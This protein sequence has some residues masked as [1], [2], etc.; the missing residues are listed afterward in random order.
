M[1]LSL[2]KRDELKG[3][4]V[5]GGVLDRI[6]RGREQRND[7]APMRRLCQKFEKGDTYWF[8]NSQGFLDFQS[9]V[10]N[11]RDKRGKPGHRIRNKYNFIQP[12]VQG[13][14]SQVT[15]KTPGFRVMPT[16]T[17]PDDVHAAELASQIA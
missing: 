10:T 14:V 13:K 8:I 12:I 6:K 7:G 1:A 5:P 3:D 9:T 16:T 4:T 2:P 11:V 17:D 15:Q